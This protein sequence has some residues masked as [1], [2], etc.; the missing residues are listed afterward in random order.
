M[1][2]MDQEALANWHHPHKSGKRGASCTYSHSAI[3][4]A[5][6]LQAV[7]HLPLRATQG[8]L[9]C[10]FELLRLDLPVPNFST[11]SRRRKTLPVSL[12]HDWGAY[13]A[14]HD[15]HLVVDSTGFK[16][17]LHRLQ[18]LWRRGVEGA[19][20][21]LEPKENLAQAALRRR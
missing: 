7:Y 6:T 9:L 4:T 12:G 1:V 11:L 17:R 13:Q 3:V 21:W 19:S 18:G 2:W 5:L 16:R 8:L 20:T 14:G 15:L 10:L